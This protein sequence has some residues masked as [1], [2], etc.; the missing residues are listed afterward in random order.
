MSKEV[1]TTSVTG[2]QKGV[3]AER[4][5]LIPIGPLLE[6]ARLYGKGAEKY[7]SHNWR[8]GYEWS[9]SYASL[10]RHAMAFWSGQDHDEHE[11]DCPP[12]CTTHTE[13]HHMASVIF[14][15]LALIE[16]GDTHPEFDD[17]YTN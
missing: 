14:H 4:V 8:K 11:P 10:Q 16:F 12:E 3:K 7:D 9:K 13:A 1:R 15:A 2:G 5:D 6:V 17:R